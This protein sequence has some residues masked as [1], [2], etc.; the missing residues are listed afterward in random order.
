MYRPRVVDE[1]ISDGL[2]TAGAVLV[3][4]PKACGKTSSAH[5][6]AGTRVHLD[7]V[8]DPRI[9][10]ALEVD[11]S[12]LLRGEAPVLLDEWQLAPDLWNL[13]R[14]E[15][16]RREHPGQFI[17]TGSSTPDDDIRRHSGAGRFTI[18]EMRPMALAESGHSSGEV[19][20]VGLFDGA[21]A[22]GYDS[23]WNPTD[24]V[25]EIAERVV[26][27]GWPTNV[28][29]P[30]RAAARANRDYLDIIRNYDIPQV[31]RIRRD[32]DKAWRVMRSL[33]RNVA[34]LAGD[35]TIARDVRE[36]DPDSG[37]DAT[38]RAT[39]TE[40]LDAMRRLRIVEDQPAWSP[41]LRSRTRVASRSKR[42]F[43]DPALAAAALGIHA[44][45]L[46]EDLQTLGF[47]FESLVTRDLRVY[48]QPLGGR[49]LHYRDERG[50]EADVV[51]ELPDGRWAAIEVKLGSRPETIDRAAHGLTTLRDKVDTSRSGEP[52]FAAVIT[53]GGI[54]YRRREDGVHVIPVRMLGP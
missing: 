13:V 3:E 50:L 14:R 25:H 4:G 30:V 28:D 19:S 29:K 46:T 21:D 27:G 36:G 8:A 18:I 49:V 5:R 6:V 12:L 26:G 23:A 53:N 2:Q 40:H 24:A 11:P 34:T 35:A 38:H 7:D 16:D 48:A 43:V 39:A 54:A 37:A 20:L 51:V 32:P 41:H 22:D 31:S 10:A 17:L 45:P 33:A 9:T 42:H 1:E 15:V 47:L 44:G 52:A